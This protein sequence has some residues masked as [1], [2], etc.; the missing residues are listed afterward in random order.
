M[1][2]VDFEVTEDGQLVITIDLNQ[3]LGESKTGKSIIV[4]STGGNVS[5]PGYEDVKIGINAYR[6]IAVARS[7]RRRY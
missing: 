4:A 6:P 2:N 1:Q 5:V 7:S 3:E